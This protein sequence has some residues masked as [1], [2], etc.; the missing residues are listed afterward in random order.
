MQL[1]LTIPLQQHLKIKSLPY[2]TPLER[3]YCWDL[4]IITLH[5]R[6]CLLSVH[7]RSRYTFVLFDVAASEWMDLQR[8]FLNGL[9]NSLAALSIGEEAISHYLQ[10]TAALELTKTHGRREV[11]FLNRAWDDVMAL[12]YTLDTSA[13]GQPLLDC[14]VNQKPSRCA[15]YDGL[16]TAAE[17]FSA[18]L[19]MQK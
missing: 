16:E 3:H 12:D 11:A 8:T 1:G 18:S 17:R 13:Q 19:K 6:P 14:A 7:C 15:G 4:H 10:C 5:S 9:R 2:G